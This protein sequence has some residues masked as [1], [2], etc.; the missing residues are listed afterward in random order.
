MSFEIRKDVF[1]GTVLRNAVQ[2][3]IPQLMR[4]EAS[5][6]GID[7]FNKWNIARWTYEI[8]NH[9]VWVIEQNRE[10]IY[11]IGFIHD[12]E[13]RE[14]DVIKLT[15]GAVGRPWTSKIIQYGAPVV[16]KEGVQKIRGRCADH[17]RD[18]YSKLG[19]IETGT[20]P[21]YFGLDIPAY[22]IE[23]ML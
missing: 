16:S 23:R 11:V 4:L 18:F 9:T 8:S 21:H 10:L 7:G 12:P 6:E 13:K 22:C 5:V 15:A 14:I 20:I 19:F 1:A 2:T 17:L 3:D